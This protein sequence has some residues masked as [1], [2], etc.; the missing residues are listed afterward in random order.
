[1]S[2]S[3]AIEAISRSAAHARR[4]CELDDDGR[5]CPARTPGAMAWGGDRISPLVPVR[6]GPGSPQRRARA[7]SSWDRA[8]RESSSGQSPGRA[9]RGRRRAGPPRRRRCRP[10]RSARRR[11]GRR[12]HL[13]DGMLGRAPAPRARRVTTTT[14]STGWIAGGRGGRRTASPRPA[15]GDEPP[16]R[17]CS[18]SRDLGAVEALDRDDR[19]GVAHFRPQRSRERQ[20]LLGEPSPSVLVVHQR[21]GDER[22]ELPGNDSS[23]QQTWRSCSWPRSLVARFPTRSLTS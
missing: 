14:S 11:R 16:G 22:L 20:G 5:G 19:G 15:R 2:R 17:S 9:P 12:G 7:A 13:G 18:P 3:S 21:V 8:R 1:M 10:L 6:G 23:S 4:P